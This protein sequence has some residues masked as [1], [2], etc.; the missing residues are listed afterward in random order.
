MTMRHGVT[1]LVRYLLTVP[2]TPASI[3]HDVKLSLTIVRSQNERLPRRTFTSTRGG[4]VGSFVGPDVASD[5]HRRRFEFVRDL[6]DR[7]HVECGE[8]LSEPTSQSS[9][10]P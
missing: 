5:V 9:L 1:D 7:F 8:L 10:E 4:D 3:R 6:R 2:G